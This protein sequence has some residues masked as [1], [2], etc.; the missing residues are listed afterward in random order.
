MKDPTQT[1]TLELTDEQYRRLLLL[2]ELGQCT[3][4]RNHEAVEIGLADIEQYIMSFSMAFNAEDLVTYSKDMNAYFSSETLD[5]EVDN[6]I[7][8][9]DN[10]IFVFQLSRRLTKRDI[11]LKKAYEEADVEEIEEREVRYWEEFDNNGVKNLY[12]K[13]N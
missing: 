7:D 13:E 6:I 5:K 9:Y 3:L 2:I 1:K 4:V 8:Y 12:L 10:H 11:E